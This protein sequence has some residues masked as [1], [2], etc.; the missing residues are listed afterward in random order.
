M[1][2]ND[3]FSR[4]KEIEIDLLSR[5]IEV[6]ERLNLRYFA[7]GGT[8]LGA[9]RHKGF[10]P[11]D[12]D[13]DVGMP[14]SDYEIFVKEGGRYFSDPY[15]LQTFSSDKEA[16]FP[17]AKL[18]DSGTT[19]IEK[20]AASLHIN[21]GVYIDIFPLDGYPTSRIKGKILNWEKA[22]LNERVLKG[23]IDLEHSNNLKRKIVLSLTAPLSS[24]GA[25]KR[26]DKLIK[27]YDYEDSYLIANY[28]G[29]WGK[30]EI[31]PKHWY[32]NGIQGTFESIEIMLP[33]KYDLWLTQVY[34][35]YNKYP[36]L[37]EQVPHHF[38]KVIDLE[39]PYTK[40]IK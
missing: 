30:K 3:H 4:L 16:I 25:V 17:F 33:E 36:P 29:A 14:R 24:Q 2:S 18:R 22:I 13:I 9:V 5:F 12:D 26:F 8:L 35:D 11:W 19:F 31:V 37:E 38:C 39:N 10:I 15:F 27:K 40:Y 21:H 23:F 34:G 1:F 7:I 20:S 32:G 6:C 28:C